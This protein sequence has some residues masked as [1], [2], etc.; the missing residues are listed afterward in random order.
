M[1][2]SILLLVFLALLLVPL[3][4]E[5]ILVFSL[6]LVLLVFIFIVVVLRTIRYEVNFFTT[7]VACSLFG[8]SLEI[9]FLHKFL[10]VFHHHGRFFID[11]ISIT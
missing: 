6:V 8:P 2:L 11:A 1:S 4:L 3:L 10:E 9:S 5:I 7:L